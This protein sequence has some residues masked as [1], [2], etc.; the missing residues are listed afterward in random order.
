MSPKARDPMITLEAAIEG[1]SYSLSQLEEHIEDF[2]KLSGP[3]F[4]DLAARLNAQ[5]NALEKY[6]TPMK[7]QIK[8]QALSASQDDKITIKGKSYQAVIN[9]IKKSC[10]DTARVREFLG[11]ELQKFLVDRFETHISFQVKE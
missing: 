11:R 3:S 4:I 7:D 8:S 1:I 5:Y 2:E 6:L 10:L 9:R